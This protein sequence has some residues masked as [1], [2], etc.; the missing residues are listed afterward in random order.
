MQ[1]Y[2]DANGRN[3]K[4]MLNLWD[5]GTFFIIAWLTPSWPGKVSVLDTELLPWCTC[6]SACVRC[7]KEGV[8]SAPA[9][10]A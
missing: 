5:T 3:L 6:H 10:M 8:I 4:V 1:D 2:S 9:K 7:H